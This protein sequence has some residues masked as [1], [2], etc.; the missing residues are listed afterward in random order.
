MPVDLL[1]VVADRGWN[2]L[3]NAGPLAATAAWWLAVSLLGWAAWPLLVRVC[4]GLPDRGYLLAKGVGWLT[5]G[6]LLWLGA[7]SRA[8][9][10]RVPHAY[11]TVAL[12]VIVGGWAAR[13]QRRRLAALW[14]AR[15]WLLLREEA[16]FSGAFLALVLVRLGNPDLWQPWFGGEKMMEFAYLNAILKSAHFPPYDP[17]FAGGYINYYY[18]GLYLVNLLV[19]LTGIVPEVAFNLAVPT[20]FALTVGLA[21]S[22]GH[23]LTFGRRGRRWLWGGV[24]AAVGVALLANLTVLA[25]WLAGLALLGG[26]PATGE[27]GLEVV[28]SF[29]A[30]LARWL[31]GRGQLPAFDYW[32]EATRVIPHTINEFPF[33]S[34][35]FADLHPHMMSMPF[36]IAALVAL[37]GLLAPVRSGCGLRGGGMWDKRPGAEGGPGVG[38]SLLGPGSLA[39]LALIAG[40]LGPLNTW[41]LPTYLGLAML[42]LVWVGIER[43]QGWRAAAQAAALLALALAL[44]APFYAHYVAPSAGLRLEPAHTRL[45]YFVVVWGLWLVALY[46]WLVPRWW[47]GRDGAG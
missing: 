41:D 11:A 26:T 16:L 9:A 6:Y 3:A 1:P 40:A 29:L 28:G 44:Y 43:G 7:Y 23:T 42:V 30:G 21:F 19:K 20:F 31:S 37:V 45:R 4:R 47:R 24:A 33:F 17:Y 46:G 14:R 25:Q 32:W 36:A 27:P 8:L 39:L 13:R 2:P 38:R 35:L 12:L 22:F 18:Y 15:R 10:N 5:A 34:F